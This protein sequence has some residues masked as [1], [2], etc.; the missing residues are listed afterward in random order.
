MRSQKTREVNLNGVT[1]KQHFLFFFKEFPERLVHQSGGG[2]I[3][4]DLG[5]R[6]HLG[7]SN[8]Y[9]NVK[10]SHDATQAH[11]LT[12]NSLLLPEMQ[13]DLRSL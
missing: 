6:D 5:P 10:N 13:M 4:G 1:P 7:G 11:T 12:P 3:W 9:A 8:T 2:H